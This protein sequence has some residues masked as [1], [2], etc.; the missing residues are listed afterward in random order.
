MAFQKPND[1]DQPIG[2]TQP[3]DPASSYERAKPEKEAGQGRLDNNPGT[4]ED[5]PDRSG[6]AVK[7]QQPSKGIAAE[8]TSTQHEEGRPLNKQ[9]S[10]GRSLPPQPEHSMME[11]ESP[12][13]DDAPQDIHDPRQ[14]RPPRTPGTNK[15][16]TP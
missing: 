2:P 6:Q 13:W 12:G 8:D 7:N 4:P 14:Q 16:G 1:P 5:Q 10:E 11:E 3:P 9:D 15:G